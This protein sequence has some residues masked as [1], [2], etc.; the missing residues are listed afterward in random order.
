[1]TVGKPWPGPVTVVDESDSKVTWSGL[2][3]MPRQLSGCVTSY[4]VL[5][6][7]VTGTTGPR[8]RK[9]II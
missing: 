6:V 8:L 9:E 2:A 3:L 4:S 5:T 1:M 7:A